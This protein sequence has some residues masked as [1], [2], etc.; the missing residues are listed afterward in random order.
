MKTP[1]GSF[2]PFK[3]EKGSLWKLHY[4]GNVQ[5]KAVKSLCVHLLGNQGSV[6]NLAYWLHSRETHRG[7]RSSAWV[8]VRNSAN[9]WR[10]KAFTSAVRTAD[11]LLCFHP[12]RGEFSKMKKK[13]RKIVIIQLIAFFERYSRGLLFLLFQNPWQVIFSSVEHPMFTFQSLWC[14]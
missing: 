13:C 3:V 1:R 9:P 2:L 12:G 14:L 5:S 4:S 6:M 8:H 11:W 10:R 7:A